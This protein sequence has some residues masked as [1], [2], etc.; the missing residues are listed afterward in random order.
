MDYSMFDYRPFDYWDDDPCIE[1]CFDLAFNRLKEKHPEN[2]LLTSDCFGIDVLNN[3]KASC[4]VILSYST[5]RLGKGGPLAMR[6]EM[7]NQVTILCKNRYYEIHN[8]D[9]Y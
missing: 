1:L 6:N 9:K 2:M 3:A 8:V 5:G 4:D 7:T